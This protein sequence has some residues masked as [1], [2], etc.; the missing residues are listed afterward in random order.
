MRIY[1]PFLTETIAEQA[2]ED[3]R[4]AAYTAG[5]A[6]PFCPQCH[7][8]GHH[9]SLCGQCYDGLMDN[10][11]EYSEEEVAAAYEMEHFERYG[12]DYGQ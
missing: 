11:P 7:G 3:T 4:L 1:D 5:A 2:T 6:D 8:S 12:N 10:A 9:G